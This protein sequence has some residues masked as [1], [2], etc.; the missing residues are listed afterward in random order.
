[1]VQLNLEHLAC[2]YAIRIEE[3]SVLGALGLDM[4]RYTS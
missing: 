4:T 2:F 3:P 1:M